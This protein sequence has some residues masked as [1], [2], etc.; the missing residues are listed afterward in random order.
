M[1]VEERVQAGAAWLDKVRPGWLTEV[2][3]GRLDLRQPDRCVL[4]QVFVA[5]LADKLFGIVRQ[6]WGER[7]GAGYWT[8]DGIANE[9][10]GFSPGLAWLQEHGF[11]DLGSGAGY[12]ILTEAW[13]DEIKRRFDSGEAYGPDR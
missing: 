2:D 10:F 8:V 12:E 9:A 3:V 6:S 7:C 1:Q 11:V 4:G 5:D 13:A